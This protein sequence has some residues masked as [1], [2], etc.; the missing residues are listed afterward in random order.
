MLLIMLLGSTLS[1]HSPMADASLGQASA[2]ENRE[3]QQLGELVT[4]K[5]LVMQARL[6][7]AWI[8]TPITRHSKTHR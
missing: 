4:G 1:E 2:T 6:D 3:H 5:I 8:A 7:L